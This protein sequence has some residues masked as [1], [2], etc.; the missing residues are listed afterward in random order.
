MN[1]NLAVHS[2]AT[3]MA[4]LGLF[5]LF[6][7]A[8]IASTAISSPSETPSLYLRL[9]STTYDEINIV[10]NGTNGELTPTIS[11]TFGKKTSSSYLSYRWPMMKSFNEIDFGTT[12]VKFHI[13]QRGNAL[14]H[15]MF[16]LTVSE[17]QSGDA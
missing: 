2:S 9:P 8:R 4:T 6:R 5:W 17:G 15:P 10:S 7:M 12:C 14:R 3:L 16:H 11:G 13:E 1:P